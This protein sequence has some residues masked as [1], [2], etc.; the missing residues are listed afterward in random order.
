MGL[1]DAIMKEAKQ[2]QENCFNY[3]F[4]IAGKIYALRENTLM[5]YKHNLP[6][7]MDIINKNY[8]KLDLTDDEKIAIEIC[9]TIVEED[10]KVDR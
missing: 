6:Y 2:E 4:E 7:M 10:R 8:D 9:N 1:F 5:K 3:G